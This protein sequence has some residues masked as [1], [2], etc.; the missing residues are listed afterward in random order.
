MGGITLRPIGMA[1]AAVGIGM[2]NL[3]Y[4]L[5]QVETLIHH[6]VFDF[7]RV[8]GSSAPQRAWKYDEVRKKRR[9]KLGK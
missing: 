5:C 7:D 2:M 6:R 3:V 1:R 9:N 4:N 8:G